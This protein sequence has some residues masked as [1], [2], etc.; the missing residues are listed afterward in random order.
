MALSISLSNNGFLQDLPVLYFFKW[1]E[2]QKK[3]FLFMDVIYTLCEIRCY[4]SSLP[5]LLP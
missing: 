3:Y 5:K 4:H 2:D 1:I